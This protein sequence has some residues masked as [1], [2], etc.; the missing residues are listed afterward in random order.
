MYAYLP[1]R[2]HIQLAQTHTTSPNKIFKYLNNLIIRTCIH[3]NIYVYT[4]PQH[5]T[6]NRLSQ[7]HTTAPYKFFAH[8]H[9]IHAHL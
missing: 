9:H 7:T 6:H 8:F 1:H 3:I 2:A 5:R 4:Y